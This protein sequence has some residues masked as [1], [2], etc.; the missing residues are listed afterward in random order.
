MSRSTWKPNYE[1]GW[2]QRGKQ[3]ASKK[4][5]VFSPQLPARLYCLW[6]IYYMEPYIVLISLSSPAQDTFWSSSPCSHWK[7]TTRAHADR[8]RYTKERY[9]RKLQ[10]IIFVWNS[11]YKIWKV[12]WNLLRT[13][14]EI[15]YLCVHVWIWCLK[16]YVVVLPSVTPCNEK[17]EA[18]LRKALSPISSWYDGQHSKTVESIFKCFKIILN[19]INSMGMCS[20]SNI[21]F[22]LAVLLPIRS[23]ITC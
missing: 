3:S 12:G 6:A 20:F 10:G 16:S 2:N 22:V 21:T 14:S 11:S 8:S 4:W 13:A 17:H 18:S 1:H 9:F 15:F 7:Y 19:S 23:Y 5:M